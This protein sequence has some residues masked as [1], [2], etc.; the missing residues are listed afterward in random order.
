MNFLL[1]CLISIS[2]IFACTEPIAAS[3]TAVDMKSAAGYVIMSSSSNFNGQG[4]GPTPTTWVTGN[5]TADANAF[6]YWNDVPGPLGNVYR[7]APQFL[8][9]VITHTGCSSPTPAIVSQAFSDF[10]SAMSFAESQTPISTDLWGGA[11]GG[12]TLSTPGVYKWTTSIG[13]SATFTISGSSSDY[14]I[15]LITGGNFQVINAQVILT[16]GIVP[17]NVVFVVSQGGA[18]M[19]VGG[20]TAAFNGVALVGNGGINLNAAPHVTG[21][22][23]TTGIIHLNNPVVTYA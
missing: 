13:I 18:S 14:Y 9:G 8:N 19:T 7:V 4:S 3:G 10:A 2:L 20:S 17:S 21:R 23:C 12:K 16:G 5:M 15:L 6:V 22:L 11:L 1:S